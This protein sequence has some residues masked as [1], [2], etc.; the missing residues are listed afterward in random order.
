MSPF[1]TVPPIPGVLTA[2]SV[3][4]VSRTDRNNGIGTSSHLV[5]LAAFL[6]HYKD[7]RT[8]CSCP[9][10]SLAFRVTINASRNSQQ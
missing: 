9:E 6:I 4:L 7:D 2:Q 5:R 8:A 3:S 10:I 1:L